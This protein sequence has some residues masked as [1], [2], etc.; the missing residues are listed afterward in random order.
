MSHTP[1]P[2]EWNRH[3][4]AGWILPGGALVTGSLVICQTPLPGGGPVQAIAMLPLG[5]EANARLIA[6]APDLLDACEF[7]RVASKGNFQF[8]EAQEKARKAIAKAK[9]GICQ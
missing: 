7:F 8:M 2:W 9:E 1:G 4:Q 3:K 5:H 6:A